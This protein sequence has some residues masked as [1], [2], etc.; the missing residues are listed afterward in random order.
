MRK[1]AIIAGCLI[2]LLSFASTSE[3]DRTLNTFQ[4]LCAKEKDPLKRQN[5][6]HILDQRNHS[7]ANIS[8]LKKEDT[9]IV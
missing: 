6:C 2:P 7:Q 5:Y 3:S 8:G 4:E 9:V 1:L